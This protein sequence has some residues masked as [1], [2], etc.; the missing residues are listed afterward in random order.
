MGF[1]SSDNFWSDE[2]LFE[3]FELDPNIEITIELIVELTLLTI[4]KSPQVI[5]RASRDRTGSLSNN[6]LFIPVDL[7]S[8]SRLVGRPSTDEG[9]RSEFLG[10]L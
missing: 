3:Y 9:P 10:S 5:E 7:S 1:F 6:R 8:I 2:N 4:E